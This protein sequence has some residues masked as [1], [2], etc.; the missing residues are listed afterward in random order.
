MPI[1]PLLI[2]N[3]CDSA[4]IVVVITNF[5]NWHTHN[6]FQNYSIKQIKTTKYARFT[7]NEKNTLHEN[8]KKK[9]HKKR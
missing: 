6:T 3:R 9:Q 1:L 2:D 8:K 4:I 5:K 7:M